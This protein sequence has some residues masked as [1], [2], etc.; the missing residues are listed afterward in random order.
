MLARACG[1]DGRV[2]GQQVGLLGDLADSID[3]R[4]DRLRL[5]SELG[6]VR[7]DLGDRALHLRYRFFG[8]LH[9]DCAALGD[10]H[11]VG[12]LAAGVRCLADDH[13][14]SRR[15]FL[16]RSVRLLGRSG[17]R[18]RDFDQLGLLLD[19]LGARAVELGDE[20]VGS[21]FASPVERLADHRDVKREELAIRDQH[22][23][24]ALRVVAQA[25]DEIRND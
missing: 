25:V 19:E 2:E 15:Q 10:F 16:R 18:L 13:L 8:L 12:G 1:L 23:R 5:D 22:A 14:G 4:G 20:C 7:A 3:D 21:A 17:K 6:D 9:V 11:A 24:E